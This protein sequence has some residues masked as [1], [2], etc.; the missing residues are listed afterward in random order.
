MGKNVV[1]LGTLDLS[2]SWS[3]E[4][5]AYGKLWE[6]GYKHSTGREEEIVLSKDELP[7]E[8]QSKLYEAP[9][10]QVEE[11]LQEWGYTVLDVKDVLPKELLYLCS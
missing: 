5:Q 9:D 1:W 7:E 10:E 2:E 8:L 3:K 6:Q 4:Y 11:L